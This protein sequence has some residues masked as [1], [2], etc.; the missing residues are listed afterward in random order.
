MICIRFATFVVS[1]ALLLAL[2]ACS[3]S[4]SPDTSLP[5][6]SGEE[7]E[8]SPTPSVSASAAPVSPSADTS[9]STSIEPT[10]KPKGV[11]AIPKVDSLNEI[12]KTVNL[13]KQENTDIEY[14]DFTIP[15]ATGKC[16]GIPEGKFLYFFFGTHDIPYLIDFGDEYGEQLRCAGIVSTIGE[17][18]PETEEEMPLEKFLSDNEI[19]DYNYVLED[20]PDMGWIF[21]SYGDYSVWIDTKNSDTDRYDFEKA[22]T[23]KRSYDVLIINIKIYNDNSI[24]RDN[25]WNEYSKQIDLLGS[26]MSIMLNNQDFYSTDDSKRVTL[27]QLVTSF[28]D[29]SIK[30]TKYAFSDIDAD[31]ISEVILVLSSGD[32]DLYYEVLSI[33]YHVAT[34]Q[35]E[36]VYGYTIPYRAFM[37][38]KT[39]GTF[40][41]SSGSADS[42][43]GKATFAEYPFA[44]DKIT[45]SKSDYDADNNQKALYF[46][47]QKNATKD[48]FNEA[49]KSQSK[50]AGVTWYDY[51]KE[52][53]DVLIA[54]GIILN[55]P[56]DC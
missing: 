56:S 50:K 42:G 20:G 27:D 29:D 7:Q 18:Y 53:I 48:E 44:I 11:N 6:V 22:T 31:G 19:F 9:P 41:F 15:G 21:F 24:I 36:G 30:I 43:F 14:R 17:M 32:N 49:I 34:N 4:P 38:L 52:N 28:G 26:C 47:N 39:D 1:I 54:T 2:T 35:Y 33:Q 37:D 13:I 25:Y 3:K 40:S 16:L 12:G 8:F 10:N 55:N 5:T 23:M 51:T 45:Y 46:V